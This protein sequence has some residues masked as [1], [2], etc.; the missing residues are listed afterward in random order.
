V[1]WIGPRLVI[2]GGV[3]P[4]YTPVWA[5]HRVEKYPGVTRRGH[6]RGQRI[7]RTG[8]SLAAQFMPLEHDFA[9]ISMADF[10]RHY[11]EGRAFIW[12]SAPRLFQEDVAYCW[13]PEDATFA[14]AIRAG[15]DLVNLSLTM[16]AY[17]YAP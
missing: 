5:A 4:D 11:N 1:A 15:G 2:P 16:E 9:L 6:F 10:R 13:A 14:P 17:V 12:A 8:A 7:E 3:V